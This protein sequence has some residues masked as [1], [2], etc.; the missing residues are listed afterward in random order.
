VSCLEGFQSRPS[1]CRSRR[2]EVNDS[3]SFDVPGILQMQEDQSEKADSSETQDKDEV[4]M[5]WAGSVRVVQLASPSPVVRFV[6]ID[7]RSYG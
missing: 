2:V 4:P 1:D 3:V 6:V 7:P 5:R